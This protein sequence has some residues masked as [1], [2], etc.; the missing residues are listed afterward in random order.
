MDQ[1]ARTI[2]TR[3][4]RPARPTPTTSPLALILTRTP[5]PTLTMALALTLTLTPTLTLVL[6]LARWARTG[7]AS[8]H[9][10]LKREGANLISL[11]LDQ[12]RRGVSSEAV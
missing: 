5:T 9:I 6:T 12:R 4:A 3:R 10:M 8:R 2:Q 11:R 1:N 7:A